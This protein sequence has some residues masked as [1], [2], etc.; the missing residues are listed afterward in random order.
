MQ[1]DHLK[2]YHIG[3]ELAAI[4]E[5]LEEN[6]GELPDEELDRYLALQENEALKVDRLC[7]W[8]ATLDSGVE[9]A[10]GQ[11][12]ALEAIIAAEKKRWQAQMD[13]KALIS[14]RVQHRLKVHFQTVRNGEALTTPSGR[15]IKLIK[16]GG[17]RAVTFP[18]E[19]E[20]DPATA[21]ERF[22]RHKIELD[23]TAIRAAVEERDAALEAAESH[24][25]VIKIDATYRDVA[26]VGLAPQG[27]RIVIK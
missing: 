7:D 19:W 15:T 16:S 3:R 13:H 17:K 10:K 18:S 12:Q 9:Y 4:E 5:L 26:M 8:I 23:K 6:G 20:Q 2:L 22:H 1:P 24:D 14:A 25:D 27:V 21:P 11:I